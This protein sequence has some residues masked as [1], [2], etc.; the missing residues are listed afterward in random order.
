LTV[1]VAGFDGASGCLHPES[2]LG[3][4]TTSSSLPLNIEVHKTL[5]THYS[6]HV[7][8]HATLET[9]GREYHISIQYTKLT[10]NSSLVQTLNPRCTN[11]K[12][13]QQ[14]PIT[15]QETKWKPCHHTKAQ[16]LAH[17]Q[18][19]LVLPS[20]LLSSILSSFHKRGEKLPILYQVPL[21]SV[22]SQLDMSSE[23]PLLAGRNPRLSCEV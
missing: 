18:A 12:C 1:A 4:P 20:I 11:N 3:Q 23:A 19:R 14:L 21:A 7:Q 5:L 2:T 22:P 17:R 13:V 16:I 10:R 9:K 6:H 15:N 8:L